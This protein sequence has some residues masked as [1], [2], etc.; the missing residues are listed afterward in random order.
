MEPR[1]GFF[2]LFTSQTKT[3]IL[4]KNPEN[5]GLVGG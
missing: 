3:E 2:A 5:P 4:K 1:I